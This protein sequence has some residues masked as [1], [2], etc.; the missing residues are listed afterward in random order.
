VRVATDRR[1]T[2]CRNEEFVLHILVVCTGNI[3][4]SP[5]AERLVAA[6]G[7]QSQNPRPPR[8]ERGD[9]GRDWPCYSRKD[10]AGPSR[11]GGDSSEFTARQLTAKI[12]LSADLLV[13]MIRE[14]RDAVLGLAPGQLHK[15]FTLARSE[16][17]RLGVQCGNAR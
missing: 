6:Y 5:T 16:S 3:C 2:A 11:L 4:R 12:A 13:T 8:L 10:R 1:L 7:A 9:S 15:T 17:T 14:H